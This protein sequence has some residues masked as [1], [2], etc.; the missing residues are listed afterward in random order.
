MLPHLI[1]CELFL[2]WIC[3][4]L[5]V[6]DK[7]ILVDKHYLLVQVYNYLR[8]YQKQTSCITGAYI[9][10]AFIIYILCCCAQTIYANL[11]PLA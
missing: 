8:L 9:I 4:P 3:Y 6:M 5:L 1:R 7:Y 10:V 2:L 11:T